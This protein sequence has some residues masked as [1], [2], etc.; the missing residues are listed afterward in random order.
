MG[1]GDRITVGA[2]KNGERHIVPIL[3][4]TFKGPKIQGDVLPLGEDW[5]LV[6]LDG[7]ME[8]YARYL[9]KTNDGYVIQVINRALIHA[10]SGA[11]KAAPYVRS[12]IDLEAPIKSPYD[13]LNHA[14]FLG[15]L[16]MPQLKPGE[17][18][19]VIIGV[20]RVL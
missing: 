17:K 3:G 18:P 20:H 4:G 8:L 2:G 7:D 14:V 9:L 6:R 19:Y 5:Q 10:P 13:Y 12:V 15:T 1:I 16:S 11:E